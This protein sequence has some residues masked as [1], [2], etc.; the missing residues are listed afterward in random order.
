MKN[1]NGYFVC[2]INLSH[3]FTRDGEGNFHTISGG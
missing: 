2:K 3:R 1:E